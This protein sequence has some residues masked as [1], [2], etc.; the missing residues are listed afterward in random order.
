MV[1][2][3]DKEKVGISWLDIS[4]GELNTTEFE[5]DLI[6]NVNDLLSVILP[7]EILAN[8]NIRN[9]DKNRNGKMEIFVQDQ[10]DDV[11]TACG[12]TDDRSDQR[13]AG[14]GHRYG[15]QLGRYFDSPSRAAF[16]KSVG[17]CL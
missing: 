5:H 12:R 6:M 8:D 7:K 16:R 1:C 13:T 14:S 3:S 2:Y 15:G 17:R 11:H 9:I 10:V 4:T